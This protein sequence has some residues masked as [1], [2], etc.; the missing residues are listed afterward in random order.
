MTSEVCNDR[1][2]LRNTVVE[3]RRRI[4]DRAAISVL[5][6]I[7]RDVPGDELQSLLFG[8]VLNRLTN[9]NGLQLAPK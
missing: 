5:D 1:A 6:V 2:L 4:L 3:R 8:D 7:P 9:Y